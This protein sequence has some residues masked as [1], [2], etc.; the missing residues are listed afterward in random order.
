MCWDLAQLGLVGWSF[1]G[2]FQPSADPGAKWFGVG[3]SGGLDRN[4]IFSSHFDTW[5]SDGV[6]GGCRML[7]VFIF[8]NKQLRKQVNVFP[9][10][11]HIPQGCIKASYICKQ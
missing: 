5:A 4:I 7:Q 2:F 3:R 1:R 11:L 9:I 6:G 8:K 10:A